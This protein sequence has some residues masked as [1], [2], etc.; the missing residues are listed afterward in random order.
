MNSFNDAANRN[1]SILCWN[2]RGLGDSEKCGVVKDAIVSANPS[3][4]CLQETKLHSIE[5]CK[6]KT[7][8]PP[9]L[10]D[11][12]CF[13]PAVGSKG[14][15]L[16]AWDC[17]SWT[18]TSTS[19]HTHSITTELQCTMSDYSIHVTNVYGPSDHRHTPAFLQELDQISLNLNE[20]WIAIGDFNLVRS[21]DEKSNCMVNQSLVSAFNDSISRLGLMEIPLLGRSFTWTNAQSPPILAKLDRALVNLQHTVAFPSTS[22]HALPKPTSDHTP[23]LLSMSTKI[24]KSQIFRFEN[25]WLLRQ[26]F[27]QTV[28]PAWLDVR[29]IEDAAGQL[30]A[31]LK[32]VRAA[33]KVW[34]RRNRAPKHTIPN[35]KFLI[36]LFDSL[37]EERLLSDNEMQARSMCHDMLHQA[38]KEK[39]AY[40]KQRSKFKAITEGDANTA[41]HHAQAT[42]RMRANAIRIVE[43]QGVQIANHQGKI[44][45]LTNF[46]SSIIG[47]PGSS[48]WN[49]DVGALFLHSARPS[50]E[51][52]RP[53]SESEALEAVKAMN[54]DSAPGP[55]GFGPSF[56]KA[57]WSSIKKEIMCFL[58]AF[59]RGQVQMERINRSFMVLIP[60]KPG[61]VAVDALRPICLQN[62]SVKILCKILTRRLQREI[63][64]LIDLHQTGFLKGRS[65]SETFVFAAEVV[66][67]CNRRK[68]PSLVL[69]LDFA[70]AFD[71]VNWAGLQCVLQA[72]G[73]NQLWC[74]W[75]DCILSSSKSAV[76]VNGCP[77][78]W[79]T[80]KRGLRQGDPLSPYLFLLVADTLQALI[81]SATEIKH[82]ID[83]EAPG[84]VLQ[85]ADD[86]LIVIRG[87]AQSAQ[88][89]KTLLDLFSA[90]T[91][92]HINFNKSTLVPIHMTDSEISQ[93]TEILGCRQEEFPQNYLGLPLS[94]SKLPN[95]IFNTYVDRSDRFLSSWQASLLNSMGRVVLINSVLDSQLV[96][97]MSATQ[98]PNEIIK[99]VDK[100]RRS[101][102][103]AGDKE[104]SSAWCLVAWQN[105]C[106]TKD[107]GGLGI[108]D[109]GVQNVCLLLHLI[110]RLHNPTQSAWAQWIRDRADL[111]NMKCSSMGNH[112]DLLSSILPLYQ[113]ITTV[114]VG[115]GRATSFWKDV[116]IGDDALADRFPRLFTHCTNKELSVRQMLDDG[117]SHSFVNRLSPQA[118]DELSQLCAI[119]DDVVLSD[120]PDT[121]NS[122]FSKGPGKL[123][124]TAIYAML[125]AQGQQSDPAST[126]I[127]E[128]AAPPRVQLFAWLLVRG[129]VHCRLNLF[130]KHVVDSPGCTVC[131]AAQESA[132]HIIFSCPFASE[133]WSALGVG[134]AHLHHTD[135]L[136]C[137]PDI[138]GL[139][140]DQ[141]NTFVILCCWQLWKRRN[142]FI[143]RN[144]SL[145]LRNTLLLCKSDASQWKARMPKK[146]KN[147]VQV[148]CQLLDQ[149]IE[150]VNPPN[151]FL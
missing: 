59:H 112:W 88:H 67:A 137:G 8:L 79:I 124:S 51:L 95:S 33:S 7:F 55:D 58:N 62:S 77:G 111:A 70:K 34:Y 46:F 104:T 105:V 108:K 133:F 89:L 73:F 52:T 22:L 123:D 119:T 118:S 96:Y 6:A 135:D 68:L 139:P 101:F 125:K 115:D 132:D 80:C 82:P 83:D 126:F 37:E 121:R 12:F 131:G 97:I 92:L 110:H 151:P 78:S 147:V 54:R 5:K 13:L 44:Q 149:A 35:L 41:F 31:C 107:L 42:V 36:H 91:G 75:M 50:D 11:N 65:I 134:D 27:V 122:Q 109:F 113:A 116:W 72:R 45:A 136:V 141:R 140:S 127:W 40:W 14:G 71:T 66:Q 29:C 15:V 98:I 56:Y 30:A 20:P 43:V 9:K 19:N 16:T 53:F 60:K 47:Q 100:R 146:S 17:S 120:Q 144:E 25:G 64:G 145:N 49:F 87:A 102:L 129:R 117:L 143:F 21:P 69:K 4:I 81:K 3:I 18:N 150:K 84:V 10:A 90:A 94:M 23:L 93:C 106:T 32:S 28:L 2:V 24:P 85:Y 39:A 99:Q 74:Q 57:V 61:A 103:W 142:G 130:R 76:L 26:S 86:T 63:G 1:L 148:W 114:C 48:V 138:P 128:N 38:I